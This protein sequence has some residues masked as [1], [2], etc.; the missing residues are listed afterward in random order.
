M[1]KKGFEVGLSKMIEISSSA[2]QQAKLV[3]VKAEYGVY[4][5]H[6]V[7]ALCKVQEKGITAKQAG[8]IFVATR[9]FAPSRLK[10]D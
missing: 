7:D 2:I 6:L 8:Q 3:E 4:L 10:G 1:N 5:A 9:A